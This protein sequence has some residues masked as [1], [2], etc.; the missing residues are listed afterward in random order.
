M[1]Q[2]LKEFLLFLKE[3]IKERLVGF[4][5]RFERLK[6]VI[7][8][9][10][11]VKRGKYSTSF[12][13]TSF[14]LLVVTAFVG[15]PIIAENNPFTS[16]L[17]QSQNV[18][19]ETVSFD[20]FSSSL[21]TVVSAKP[22]DK[23]VNYEVLGGDTLASIGQKFG[24]S[25]DTL[26][27]ANDLKSQTI[28]PG[29]IIKV[30]PVTGIVHKVNSGDSIYSIA[31]KYRT[32]AQKIVNFPFNDFAD[33]DTFALTPGQTLFVPDGVI[34]AAPVI[35][36]PQYASIKAGV[37]GSSSFIWPTSG[38][39]TQYPVSYHM[40][41]DIANN[42]APPILASDT[43]TV[44]FA[45]CLG[46][47][48][49]CHIIVNHANGY[50]TLYGHLSSIGVSAGQAVSQGQQIGVMGCTGRCSGTHLH[51]EVRSGGGQLNPLSF[52]K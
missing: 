46:Y 18:Q 3:Y 15:G 5:Q 13:N 25:V 41:L 12:L 11:I 2:D 27:W 42:G 30:P 31:K 26:K 17:E 16:S 45:G 33:L 23:I 36:A 38:G 9:F 8:A 34:E 35:S 47:G 14:V 43:G 21:G 1:V 22:R 51:F 24:V 52:L 32:N 48:Y 10:L 37:Q 49:G 44:V 28:K 7:V 39:I 4:G 6:N 20:P 29:Q 19:A 40:A 50:E